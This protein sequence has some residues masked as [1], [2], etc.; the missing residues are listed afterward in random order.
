MHSSR[1]RD[2]DVGGLDGN[3]ASLKFPPLG[4]HFK[5]QLRQRPASEKAS[6]VRDLLLR[7]ELGDGANG[8]QKP[9]T[10]IGRSEGIRK[11]P[12]H[13][14]NICGKEQSCLGTCNTRC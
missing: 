12:V 6:Q 5:F 9:R 4:V 11:V 8:L 3:V 10:T 14:P 1:E 13:P 7:Q 2:L